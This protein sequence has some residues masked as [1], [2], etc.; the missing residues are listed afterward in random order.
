VLECGDRMAVCFNAP[1]I[2]L[3]A[4]SEARRQAVLA[5]L[6]PDVLDPAFDPAEVVRRARLEPPERA[7]GEVLLGQRVISGIGNIWR[8]ESLFADGVNPWTPVADLDDEGLAR[9]AATAAR[10]MR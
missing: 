8:S 1:V 4:P 10:L 7:I 5:G 6:G 9:L 3:L 2:E